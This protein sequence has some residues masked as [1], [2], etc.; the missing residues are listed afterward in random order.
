MAEA[1][2]LSNRRLQVIKLVHDWITLMSLGF[3]VEFALF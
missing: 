1:F 2:F 3:V